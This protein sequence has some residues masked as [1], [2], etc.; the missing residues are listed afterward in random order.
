MSTPRTREVILFG[1]PLNGRHVHLSPHAE[2]YEV[3][4]KGCP[5]FT[6]T[7]AGKFDQRVMFAISPRS[8]SERR[9]NKLMIGIHGRDPRVEAEFAKEK[10]I[11]GGQR[12]KHG[13]GRA[14]REAARAAAA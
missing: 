13:R 1:G 4:P 10:P 9:W 2:I 5:L 7:Y 6:Y 8:R 14:R 12:L 3:G 11:V